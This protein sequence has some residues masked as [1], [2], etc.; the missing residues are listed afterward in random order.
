[1][2]KETKDRIDGIM[3]T[4]ELRAEDVDVLQEYWAKSVGRS[5]FR[6]D[7]AL[8]FTVMRDDMYKQRFSYILEDEG[9][10]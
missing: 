9:E 5:P 4:V 2:K 8:Y 7:R 10:G 1:M 6:A 3:R